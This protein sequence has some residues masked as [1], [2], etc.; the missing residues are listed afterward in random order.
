MAL[1]LCVVA[2]DFPTMNEYVVHG[3][4]GLLYDPD[5]PEPLDFSGADQLGCQARQSALEGRVRWE[6]STEAILAFFLREPRM[7]RRRFHP[8]IQFRGRATAALRAIFR[9]GKKLVGRG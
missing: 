2:P 9:F 4:T 8:W 6:A 1:G 5:R 3:E 7:D